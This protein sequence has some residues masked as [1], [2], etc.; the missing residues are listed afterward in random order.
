VPLR[1]GSLVPVAV[2]V[3]NHADVFQGTLQLATQSDATIVSPLVPSWL[4]DFG[5]SA[6]FQA[7]AVLQL[8][9]GT[10]TV[11]DARVAAT[12]PIAVD[13]LAQAQLSIDH[14]DGDTIAS[15]TTA[16]AATAGR[17]A[18]LVAAI[19]DLQAAA[20]A[21]AAGDRAG[22]VG[23]LLAAAEEAGRSTHA[24]ADAF[25]SRIDWVLWRESR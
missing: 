24:Q 4:L 10:T 8:G 19:I 18:P 1:T 9:S 2:S 17:D 22:V 21:A 23:A 25:R 12:S 5:P 16:L 15:L 7:S 3:Q 6:T 13:P 11:L 20:S 14:A